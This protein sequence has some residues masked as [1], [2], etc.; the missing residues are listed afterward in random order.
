MQHL[1]LVLTQ[2]VEPEE[3]EQYSF[4]IAYNLTDNIGITLDYFDIAVKNQITTVGRNTIL[5]E[6][7]SGNLSSYDGLY[8]TRDLSKHWSNEIQEIGSNVT[9][10]LGFET[11]GV[12]L[13]ID[14][15]IDLDDFGSLKIN[16]ELAYTIDY[17]YQTTS[18]SS[19]YDWVGME[20][21]PEIRGNLSFNYNYE[22]FSAFAKVRY[23]G[24]FDGLEPEEVER[25]LE[26]INTA[27]M[28]QV[29]VGI[30]YAS[31]D[32][33][34]VTLR[35]V[36]AFDEMPEVNTDLYHGYSTS[37]HSIIGREIQVTWSR[38]F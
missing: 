1:K 26:R 3:S 28:T 23:I 19:V 7:A 32:Y 5:K 22:E 13:N 33:G 4:G 18:T 21:T 29:D 14:S 25:G 27:A 6:E 31:D 15:K 10:Y 37:L 24:K 2:K 34:T 12:D 30:G 35:I 9:N 17:T 36:N 20:D 16:F 38:S 8:V 11:S